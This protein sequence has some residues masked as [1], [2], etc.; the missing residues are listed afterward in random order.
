MYILKIILYYK[1]HIKFVPS[2]ISKC[3]SNWSLKYP[4]ICLFSVIKGNY[5]ELITSFHESD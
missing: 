1:H 3:N 4:G 5:T 2:G